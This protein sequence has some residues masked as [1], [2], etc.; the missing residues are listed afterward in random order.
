MFLAVLIGLTG[1]CINDKYLLKELL[2]YGGDS[3]VF[4]AET[5]VGEPPLQQ[6]AIKLIGLDTDKEDEQ[7]RELEIATTLKHPHLIDCHEFFR[8]VID[9]SPV[10]GLVMELADYSLEQYLDGFA[11][12]CIDLPVREAIISSALQALIFI[13]SQGIVHRDIKPG[14]VLKVGEVW[15]V[16]DFGISRRLNT[17]TS[18]QTMQ[19]NGTFLFMPPEA[20]D[21]II[22]PAWDMWSLGILITRLF[23]KE[24]PFPADNDMQRFY[25]IQHN[26]PILPTNINILY[27]AIIQ[28]CLIKS[29]V[30]RWTALQV[31]EYFEVTKENNR[32]EAAIE[33]FRQKIHEKIEYL[34]QHDDYHA[35]IN[36][37]DIILY[38]KPNC[39]DAW[40][41]KADAYCCL[42]RT[43]ESLETYRL[44][45]QTLSGVSQSSSS[46]IEVSPQIF[47]Q[48]IYSLARPNAESSN[49]DLLQNSM[50]REIQSSEGERRIAKQ[51][52]ERVRARAQSLGNFIRK[53]KF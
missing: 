51:L 12:Q 19:M 39:I 5:L 23:T 13:H 50:E 27:Q 10:L 49:E 1:R 37:C 18:T 21:G 8:V 48:E 17:K 28:G 20:V 3:V 15:K 25:K 6:V 41:N 31:S 7:I 34:K 32:S 24:H 53:K 44:A 29:R 22:S 36:L 35:I 43:K 9:E 46:P 26:A 4:R 2:G 38:I 30:E 14:N 45:L 47:K 11:N 52:A 33:V 42:G 40:Q 16:A